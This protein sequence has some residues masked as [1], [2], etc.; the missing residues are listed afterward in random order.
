MADKNKPIVVGSD[1]FGLPLK[2]TVRDYLRSKGYQVDDFGVET[3]APIDY[4]DIADAVSQAVRQGKYDRGILICGTGAGMAI[5]ANKVPGVRAVFV[6]DPYTAE[7]ARASNDAQIITMGSQTV[8][9]AVAR[10]LI[11]IWLESE[12]EGGRSA[13]KVVKI[14]ALDEKYR[15]QR[16][17]GTAEVCN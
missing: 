16:E 13:P 8:A 3:D 17:G 2:N 9:P 1:H 15:A 14:K 7:R 12:F 10:K 6:G 11:D 4:P 5:V